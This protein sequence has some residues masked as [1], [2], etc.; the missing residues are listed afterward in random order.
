MYLFACGVK[1][2]LGRRGPLLLPPA[3]LRRASA[4]AVHSCGPPVGDGAVA[5]CEI[6]VDA[7]LP[8]LRV[9]HGISN[10]S[11]K[12]SI[13]I[14]SKGLAIGRGARRH[15]GAIA[16]GARQPWPLLRLFAPNAVL[17]RTRRLNNTAVPLPLPY[18]KPRV[19]TPGDPRQRLSSCRR[20]RPRALPGEVESTPSRPRA[21]TAA[22]LDR[23]PLPLCHA[24]AVALL[25]QLQLLEGEAGAVAFLVPDCADQ[26]GPKMAPQTR[27]AAPS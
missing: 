2:P 17:S 6:W 25:L 10:S 15:G 5:F 18:C 13:V 21:A 22:E 23:H 19:A 16:T 8:D 27:P 12:P 9:L 24:E 3:G 7:R 14:I 1:R 4:D 26:L 11:A 20:R